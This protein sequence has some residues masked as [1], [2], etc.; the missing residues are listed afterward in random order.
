MFAMGLRGQ[1][2]RTKRAEAFLVMSQSGPVLW[3]FVIYAIIERGARVQIVFIV[4]IALIAVAGAYP[5]F[6]V[7]SRDARMMTSSSSG[8]NCRSN[9]RRRL[10]D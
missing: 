1:G 5:L 8:E 10:R 2:K 9:A 6:L 7:L 4:V 3:F